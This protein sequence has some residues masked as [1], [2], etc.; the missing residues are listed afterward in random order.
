MFENYFFKL[1][2]VAT[3]QERLLIESDLYWGAYG[4]CIMQIEQNQQEEEEK[5]QTADLQ[6]V[7]I[8]QFP[9]FKQIANLHTVCEQMA[10]LQ[11]VNKK[12]NY[13]I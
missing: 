9:K 13:K 1:D 8:Q 2:F 11:N 12:M 5:N 10:G 3:I 4:I 7:N 6:N